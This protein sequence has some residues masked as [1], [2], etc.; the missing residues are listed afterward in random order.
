MDLGQQFFEFEQWFK[1]PSGQRFDL[2]LSECLERIPPIRGGDT[3]LQIANCGQNSWLQCMNYKTQWILSP[4]PSLQTDIIASP[5]ASPLAKHSV[6]SVFAPFLFDLMQGEPL[7]LVYELDRILQSMGHLVILGLNPTGLWK[8]S[9]FFSRQ[10]LHWYQQKMTYSYWKMKSLF[11]NLGYEQIDA[12]FFYF[13]PPVQSQSWINYFDIVNR[14][15][16]FIAFYPPAFYLLTLQK[17]EFSW[18]APVF[19]KS[20]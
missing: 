2:E 20:N 13:I 12:Q 10:A 1:S 19:A 3:L 7:F 18:V 16:R 5:L 17:R 6:Q 4:N 14:I 9:R 8:M 15:S 11:K